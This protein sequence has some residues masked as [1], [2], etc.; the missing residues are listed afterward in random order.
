MLR[1][2]S[3]NSMRL[4]MLSI[5]ISA[6]HRP[7]N[8]TSGIVWTT[9]GTDSLNPTAINATV[10][11]NKFPFLSTPS[12]SPD[13]YCADFYKY[14][15]S[16]KYSHKK[17]NLFHELALRLLTHQHQLVEFYLIL[18][19]TLLEIFQVI[20]CSFGVTYN[21]NVRHTKSLMLNTVVSHAVYESFF[22]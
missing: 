22:V 10:P 6:S 5:N 8:V 7:L 3:P 11:L 16:S 21:V 20:T 17:R 14:I 12:Y 9:T 19:K 2:Q 13:W 4:S 18:A 1:I 15:S